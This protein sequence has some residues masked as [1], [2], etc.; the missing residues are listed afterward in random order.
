MGIDQ[1]ITGY[2]LR[3]I[4]T[5]RSIF[6]FAIKQSGKTTSLTTDPTLRRIS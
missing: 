1:D 4:I 3:T 2:L 5:N 6:F